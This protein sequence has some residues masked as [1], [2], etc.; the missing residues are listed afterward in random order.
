MLS[1]NKEAILN[2]LHI[3]KLEYEKHFGVKK[4]GLF[5]S[6]AR[7]EANENSDIDLVVEMH[8]KSLQKRLMLKR[9]IEEDLK[10]SVDIGYLSSLRHF[11]VN[12]IKKDIIYI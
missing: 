12:E 3:H 7:D 2:Y 8:P 6:Y 1:M 9:K 10:S 5:G 11:I 4:I